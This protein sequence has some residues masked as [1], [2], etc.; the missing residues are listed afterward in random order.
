MQMYCLQR[1]LRNTNLSVT[2]VHPGGVDIEIR[3]DYLDSRAVQM[4][5]RFRRFIGT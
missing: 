2:S 5:V 4:L 1:R 3:R